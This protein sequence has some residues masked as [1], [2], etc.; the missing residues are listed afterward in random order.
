DVFVDLFLV[1]WLNQ[2]LSALNSEDHLNVNLSV[3]VGHRVTPFVNALSRNRRL[4]SSAPAGRYV[5]RLRKIGPSKAACLQP[6]KDPPQR[7]GIFTALEK[8][9]PARQHVYSLR[10]IRPSGAECL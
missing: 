4:E 6:S 7:G 10:K 8:P 2:T 1:L 5:G 3:G 9:T